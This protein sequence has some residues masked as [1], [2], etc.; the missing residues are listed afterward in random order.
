MQAL[1]NIERSSYLTGKN[2]R[3]WR[4]DLDFMLQAKSFDRLHDGGY[5]NGR[6]AEVKAAVPMPSHLQA[7]VD[8]AKAAGYAS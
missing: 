3:G 2:D 4:A 5:G 8:E 1:A 6:H 7:L